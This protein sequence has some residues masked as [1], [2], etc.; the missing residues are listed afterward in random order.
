[1]GVP[2]AIKVKL[3]AVYNKL[4]DPRR[5]R[6]NLRPQGAD[7]IVFLAVRKVVKVGKLGH[8]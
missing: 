2:T 3:G 8:P 5:Q 1:M 6:L 4:R 7:Q